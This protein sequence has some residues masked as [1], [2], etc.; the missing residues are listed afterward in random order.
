MKRFPGLKLLAILCIPIFTGA[1]AVDRPPT[2]G[3]PDTAPLA[4]TASSPEPGSLNVATESIRIKFNRYVTAAE[5]KKSLI[6]SPVI[7]EYELV[8]HGREAEIRLT[9]PLRPAK[10]Y[11]ITL[12]KSLKSFYGNE[13]ATNW[14]LPF[15]T[16]STIDTGTLEG[17]VWA[18][19][20]APA[21]NITVM[22]FNLDPSNASPPDSLP[23]TPDYATQ[24]EASG[25]FRFESLAPGNY[26]IVAIDD[27]NANFRFD[28]NKEDFGVTGHA[29]LSTGER[30]ISVRLASGDTT[31]VSI[32]SAR[33]V[34]TREIEITFNRPVTTRSL[35]ISTISI[36]EQSDGSPLPV[37]GFFGANRGEEES[38]FRLLTGVM[39][40]KSQYTLTVSPGTTRGKPQELTFVGGMRSVT[41]PKLSVTILPPDK[42]VNALLDM[43]RPDAG[44]CIEVQTNLPVEESS[45][46]K[47]VALSAI[48]KSGEQPLP[49]TVSRY[50]HRT[51]LVR[52]DAG[53]EPGAD[54]RV[55]VHPALITTLAGARGNDT[56]LVSRFSSAGPEQ[57]GEI[58]GTGTTTAAA[59][60]EARRAGTTTVFRTT[61]QPSAGGGF[62]YAFRNLPPG[63]Y[64]IFAFVPDSGK[65][66]GTINEWDAGSLEP[67]RTATPF[68]AMTANV[69][70]GWTTE[71]PAFRIPSGKTQPATSTEAPPVRKQRRKR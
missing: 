2:G 67:F 26:R 65:T 61:V 10:T 51:W 6:F 34:N 25:N 44:P 5:L 57:Y 39:N 70:Q 8:M 24:T 7:K 4:V 53:F 23:S 46:R 1:C 18:R 14:S 43:V 17:N 41:W 37:L 66:S 28:R 21:P 27:K 30:D 12:R 20:L 56:L 59:V 69:R 68:F 48:R 50:D 71:V 3:P 33:P 63:S 16:G 42:A 54:Y 9:A 55:A 32:R 19:R 35:D 29:S 49:I 22:A 45:V 15:S 36:R 13:L 58:T 60:V 40:P 38:T 62:S 64:T 52:P 47:A 11:T 31:E